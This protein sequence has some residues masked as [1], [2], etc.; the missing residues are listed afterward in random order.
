MIFALFQ[1]EVLSHVFHVIS[2]VCYAFL[3]SLSDIKDEKA[4]SF[5]CYHVTKLRK[6][7]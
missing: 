3:Y 1:N 7:Y 5:A 6:M 4:F 2:L